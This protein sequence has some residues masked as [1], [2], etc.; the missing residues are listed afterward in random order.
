MIEK[1]LK[2]SGM[3]QENMSMIFDLRKIEQIYLLYII[4]NHKKRSESKMIHFFLTL[5]IDEHYQS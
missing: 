2:K 1:Y 5:I 3:R 4:S